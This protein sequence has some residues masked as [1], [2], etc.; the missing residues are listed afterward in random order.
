M[1]QSRITGLTIDG[2]RGLSGITRT[3]GPGGDGIAAAFPDAPSP[4][5]AAATPMKTST[6]MRHAAVMW[7]AVMAMVF[8]YR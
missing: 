8:S 2:P 5:S 1:P 4:T 3:K 7:L 6:P